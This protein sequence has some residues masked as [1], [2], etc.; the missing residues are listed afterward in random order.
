MA[1]ALL[2]AFL[3]LVPALS[4]VSTKSQFCGSC[5]AVK[6]EVKLL[7]QS[8][9]KNINCV[10]CHQKPGAAG[11][12]QFLIRGVGNFSKWVLRSD[13]AIKA[14]VDDKSCNSCHSQISEVVLTKKGIAVSHQHFTDVGY[15]C[16]DCHNTIAHEGAV[17]QPNFA[18]I[19]KCVICH[20]GE[21]A[22][23]YPRL[24]DADKNK[25]TVWA[26]V[27]GPDKLKTHGIGNLNTCKGCHS[28][29]FCSKC[30][31]IDLPHDSNFT[32]S[33]GKL[34]MAK[35]ATCLKCHQQALCNT[36]HQVNMPHPVK[37]LAKHSK[38]TAKTGDKVCVRCHSPADCS[39]CHE[40]HIHPGQ[41][42]Q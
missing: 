10:S 32:L 11:F 16:T 28:K 5:H 2:I 29:N 12:S 24:F 38:D 22:K 15:R 25:T 21:K 19:D 17:P 8:K 37:W 26:V 27:H 35:E 31:K 4:F 23:K 3:V 13:Q 18:S 33:H 42:K 39:D 14:N 36:C 34:S 20:N 40:Q 9:H 30:H 41:G 7:S 6:Q 1:F